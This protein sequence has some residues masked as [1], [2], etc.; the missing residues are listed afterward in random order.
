VSVSFEDLENAFQKHSIREQQLGTDHPDVA[1]SL[2]NL[3]MLYNSQGRYGDAEPLFVR[4]L[5]IWE[6]QLGPDHPDVATSFNNLA[7]LYRSQ[8][9]YEEAE[10]LL[11]RSVRILQAQLPAD[12]P[13]SARIVSNL[14]YLYDLQG[15]DREAEALYRQALPI[16][17]AKLESNHQWRQE[18]SQRFCSFLQKVIQEYR[19]DELSD[20]PMTQVVLK[21]LR[22]ERVK[23]KR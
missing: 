10:P 14:A 22:K 5:S 2:N 17:S 16:L 9:R 13:L 1:T 19:T 11:L 20:D 18:A 15:R 4:S 6:Q 12:H 3:A 21:E 7:T 8:G 23:G